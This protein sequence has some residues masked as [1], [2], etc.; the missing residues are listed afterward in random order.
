[1][2]RWFNHLKVKTSLILVLLFFIAA[3]IGGAA[4][5]ILSLKQNNLALQQIV[6]GQR[7]SDALSQALDSYKESQAILGRALAS[8]AQNISSEDY[9]TANE[10]IEE[11]AGVRRSL[12]K[13]TAHLIAEVQRKVASSQE[14]FIRYQELA[15]HSPELAASQAYLAESYNALIKAGI[16]PLINHL[17]RGEIS[18]FNAHLGLQTKSLE[19]KL[20]ANAEQQAWLQQDIMDEHADRQAV[21]YLWVMRLVGVG[22]V[23]ALVISLLVYMFLHH[24][25]L[26]PL[27]RIDRHFSE[28]AKGN[29]TDKIATNSHNEIGVLFI[30]L[31]NMQAALQGMVSSVRQGVEQIRFNAT[32]IYTGTENLSERSERQLTA[33]QQTAASMEQLA[34]TVHQNTENAFQATQVA[35]KSSQVATQGGQAVSSVVNT[36]DGISTSADKISEIVNVIDSIAFQTNILALNAAVEAARA[37]E[38]GR[39]FAVVAGEVRSLA[40]RSAQAAREIK[41]LITDSLEQVQKGASQVRHAGEV[42]NEVVQAVAG[43]STL[44]NE[45]SE[46]SK[47]Q[48]QGIN[49][50]N[51]AVSDM[52][53]AVQRNTQLVQQAALSAQSL[54]LQAERLADVVALFQIN[55][56]DTDY[57]AITNEHTPYG[58][59]E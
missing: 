49:Q 5:G 7:A 57:R 56:E 8:Y 47:E 36:M 51:H 28:I 27:R 3:L 19:D 34:S 26:S 22:M 23:M 14:A 50:V 37:G 53:E 15:E 44:M 11:G 16:L 32:E 2:G 55:E 35:E 46:A 59:L 33:L 58:V 9:T 24:M 21:Q 39:G 40:Q 48:D 30:G 25:V 54:Q 41:E 6:Q 38:Q 43:V 13:Q 18:Q 31:S 1:M 4:L 10:W 12:D 29:L 17:S 42:V 45:I 52:D 20:Y